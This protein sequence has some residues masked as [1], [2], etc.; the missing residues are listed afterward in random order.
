MVVVMMWNLSRRRIVRVL[1]MMMR[2]SRRMMGMVRGLFYCRRIVLSQDL[3]RVG[4]VQL[5][6]E[7]PCCFL[8]SSVGHPGRTIAQHIRKG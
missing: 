6:V 4:I 1:G 2:I 8:F 7:Q 3:R 5:V